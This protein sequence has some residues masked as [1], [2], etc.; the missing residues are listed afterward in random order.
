[1]TRSDARELAIHLI[2]AHEFSGEDPRDMI[3]ARLA[4][5]YYEKLSCEVE[6]YADRPSAAQRAYID[7]VVSGVTSR[8]EALDDMIKQFSIGWD[9][10]RISKLTR[11]ILQLAF[12]EIQCIDDVP[13]GVAISEAVRMAKVYDGDDTGA[14]VNGIL[15]SYA[16]SLTAEVSE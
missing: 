3:A 8:I 15:G 10:S 4:K 11:A 1:M 16:R 7:R 13:T 2:Y 9:V 14:F 6:L 12:F 5:D